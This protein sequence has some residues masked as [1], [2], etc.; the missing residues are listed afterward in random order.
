[1]D[2]SQD[3]GNWVTLFLVTEPI[4]DE[5]DSTSTPQW[6]GVKQDRGQVALSCDMSETDL[7]SFLVLS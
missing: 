5:V 6:A 1:M 2:T 4:D 3:T 7:E